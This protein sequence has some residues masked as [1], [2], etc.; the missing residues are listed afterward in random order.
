M[1]AQQQQNPQQYSQ[2]PIPQGR[3]GSEAAARAAGHLQG[4]FGEQASQQIARLNG[5]LPPQGN[6]IKQEDGS[7]YQQPIKTDQTDG[8]GDALDTWQAEYARR[9]AI[10]AKDREHN[11]SVIRDHVLATQQQLE[12]GGLL[13]PLDEH[14]NI[15]S[16]VRRRATNA[17]KPDSALARSQGDA[18]DDDDEEDEDAINSDLDDP[19]EFDDLNNHGD[20]E[21]GKVM[22]CTYDKVQRVKNKWKCILKDGILKLDQTE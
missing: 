22:L 3:A 5:T 1:Q 10:I 6:Y 14:P 18:A 15:V 21:S 8:S 4:R 19:D 9:K 11:D 7:Q 13:L 2:P 20:E 12:G 17:K 16:S